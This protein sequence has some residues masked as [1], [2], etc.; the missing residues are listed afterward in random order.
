MIDEV[1][2]EILRDGLSGRIVLE[3]HHLEQVGLVERLDVADLQLTCLNKQI[4]RENRAQIRRIV[5]RT[6]GKLPDRQTRPQ[7][8]SPNSSRQQCRGCYCC[9]CA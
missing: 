7:V 4:D 8:W 3:L 9:S 5:N 2:L 1:R 6:D